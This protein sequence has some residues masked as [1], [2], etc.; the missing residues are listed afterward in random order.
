MAV[1]QTLWELSD[2]LQAINAELAESPDGLTPELEA[3]L[4]ALP[5]TFAEKLAAVSEF[6]ATQRQWAEINKAEAAR[7][8][9]LAKSQL[10]CDEHLAAYQARAIRNTGPIYFV[11]PK[12]GAPFYEVLHPDG[13]RKWKVKETPGKTI[14][15]D[16]EMLPA[17]C[18]IQI[19]QADTAKVRALLDANIPIEGAHVHRE[20]RLYEK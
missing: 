7:L 10:A 2:E 13:S 11:Q 1:R 9:A 4:D 8:A 3:R 12:K 5:G 17:D 6:R 20:W 16:V 18:V 19:P 14:I 15:D